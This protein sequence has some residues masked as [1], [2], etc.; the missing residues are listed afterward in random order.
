MTQTDLNNA[1]QGLLSQSSNNSNGV[2]SIAMNLN[3]D[4]NPTQMQQ[5]VDRLEELIQALW[6]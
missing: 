4:Y 2:G 6:R 3:P 5:V 1:V